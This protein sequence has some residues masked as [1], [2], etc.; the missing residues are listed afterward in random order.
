MFLKTRSVYVRDV[1]VGKPAK[2]LDFRPREIDSLKLVEVGLFQKP[3]EITGSEHR[4]KF[5]C[6]GRMMHRLNGHAQEY[7]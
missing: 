7:C 6:T 4:S 3:K 2:I 5:C 1:L